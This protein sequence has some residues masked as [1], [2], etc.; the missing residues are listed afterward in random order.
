MNPPINEIG[1]ECLFNFPSGLSRKSKK[2]EIKSNFKNKIR[3]NIN[4]IIVKK[5]IT[6]K[7]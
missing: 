2:L 7:S 5:K 6:I 1:F 3:L 4:I